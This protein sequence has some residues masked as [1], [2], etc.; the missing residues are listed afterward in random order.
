M[1]IDLISDSAWTAVIEGRRDIPF[2]FLALQ[3]LLNTLRHQLRAREISILDGIRELK[4]FYRKFNRLPVAEKDFRKIAE[5]EAF[6][7]SWLLDPKEIARRIKAGQSLMLAGEEGLLSALPPGNWIGGTIPY[8]M[9]QDGGCLCSDKIFVTE[10][11]AEFQASVHQYACPELPRLYE[12]VDEGTVT[13]VILPA[14]SP[15]HTEF[16][17]RAPRYA[18]FAQHPLVGWVAGMDLAMLGKATPKVFCGGP[19]PLN[20]GAAVMRMRLPSDRMAQ[21]KIINLFEPGQGDTI[22]FSSSGF[23]AESR[24]RNYHQCRGRRCM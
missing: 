8:F 11:P 16:A 6:L 5:Q 2:E 9:A 20:D 17:L 7:T 3:V 18:S 14:D 23:S 15:A 21:I 13:F 12:G 4:N 10:I 22:S 19:Q 24:E 1:N